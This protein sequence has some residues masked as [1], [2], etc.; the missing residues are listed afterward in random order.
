MKIPGSVP[1]TQEVLAIMPEEEQRFWHEFYEL[2]TGEIGKNEKAG[3]QQ[4]YSP[5]EELRDL[6][7]MALDNY[8]G[9]KYC[10]VQQ[11]FSIFAF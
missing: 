9:M 4:P 1:L 6:V 8:D 5:S 3:N 2:T 11:L 10:H 7:L